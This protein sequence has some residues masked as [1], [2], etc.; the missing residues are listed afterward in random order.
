[1]KSYVR[2][3]LEE[4]N[5]FFS[6]MAQNAWIQILEWSPENWAMPPVSNQRADVHLFKDKYLVDVMMKLIKFN[7]V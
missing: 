5:H 7:S 2:H 4:V 1:M 3:G 6:E